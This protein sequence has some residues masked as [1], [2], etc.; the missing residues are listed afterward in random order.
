[1]KH[2]SRFLIVI[3]TI[4]LVFS[5]CL[6]IEDVFDETL[7]I[8]KWVSGTEHYRYDANY[9]GV[10]WDTSDDVME[11]EGQAFTWEL[12]MTTMTHIHIMEKGGLGVPKIYTVTKLTATTLEYTDD[13]K[14]T[15]VFTKL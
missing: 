1:M 13:F 9:K 8:G 11:S 14:K 3:A 12:K 2:S 15:H 7:L 10:T 5:S 4:A 6:P